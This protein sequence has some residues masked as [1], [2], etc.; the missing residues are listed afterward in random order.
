MIKTFIQERTGK[1]DELLQINTVSEE[2]K[3]YAVDK[4]LDFPFSEYYSTV[5]D[6][7]YSSVNEMIE[8]MKNKSLKKEIDTAEQTE[9]E[10]NG[11]LKLA[12]YRA[13]HNNHICIIL[14][15]GKKYNDI[16][17]RLKAYKFTEAEAV[18]KINNYL[19]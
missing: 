2:V 19:V 11:L 15:D 4:E 12:K 17:D 18:E 6:M 14:E 10:I 8:A 13:E 7:G 9:K 5:S 1:F 3:I 16:V